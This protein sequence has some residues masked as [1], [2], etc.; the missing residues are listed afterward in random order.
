MIQGDCCSL[1]IGEQ[2]IMPEVALAPRAH[3]LRRECSVT[4]RGPRVESSLGPCGSC[5]SADRFYTSWFERAGKLPVGTSVLI[6]LGLLAATGFLD[7]VTGPQIA[8]TIVYVVPITWMTW[9]GGRWAGL[10]MALAC[11]AT[12]LWAELQGHINYA[13]LWIPYWNGLVRTTMF[14]LV[15]GLQSE[16][17]ERKRVERGLRQT[18][19]DLE[20]R[21]RELAWSEADLQKQTGILQSILDS[22]GDGVLVADSRGALIHMNPA[23]RRMLRMPATDTNVIDWLEAQENYQPDW[24]TAPGNGKNPLLS[25]MRGE[26]VDAVETFL[27]HE[28]L[29]KGIWLSVTGR[30]LVDPGDR[31]TGGVIVFSDISARKEL[32]RQIAEVSDRE[33]RRIGEDLHDG[34][35]QHLV[36]TALAARTL[37]AKLSDRSLPEAEDATVIAELLSESIAQARAVA[38]GLYLVQLEAGGLN[39]ALDDLAVQVRSRQRITCEFVERVSV[40]IVEELVATSLFRIAQEAVNNAIKHA[41]AGHIAVALS[42]DQQQIWLSIE[43]DGTGFKPDPAATRGM[44]LH[45]MSYRARMMGAAL[46]I[47]PRADGGTRV[48]CAVRRLN[49]TQPVGT[50]VGQD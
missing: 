2:R 14:C 8:V 37:V 46:H 39:S 36:S 34:L 10:G 33:Q 30:P 29:E 47:G 48:T 17:I 45:I 23:A 9:T 7:W 49:V 42:A 26:A 12:W 19:G 3:S 15:S 1:A 28:G 31:T 18:Q 44:G 4:W 41:H 32:E 16:V 6:G 50:H 25:A 35:C 22:M 40:P 20:Q 13:E 38:R 43:D 24:P 11:G 5:M 21:A 27:Q